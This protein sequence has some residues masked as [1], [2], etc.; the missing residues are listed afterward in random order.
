MK[1]NAVRSAVAAV[2]VAAMIGG[3]APSAGAKDEPDKW[4]SSLTVLGFPVLVSECIRMMGWVDD[5]LPGDP[6]GPVDI[7]TP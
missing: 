6:G 4:C 3:F 7:P 2:C 5:R 1:K